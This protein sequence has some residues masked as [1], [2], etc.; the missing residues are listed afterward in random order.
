MP[1]LTRYQVT[2]RALQAAKTIDE[3]GEVCSYYGGIAKAARGLGDRE[4]E[5]EAA[6][7][8]I[9]AKRKLGKLMVAASKAGAL[10]KGTRGHLAGQNKGGKPGG[11]KKT[12]LDEP[13]LAGAHVDKNLAN[14]ARKLGRLEPE[15]FNRGLAAWRKSINGGGE[16]IKADLPEPPREARAP[17][18]RRA[19]NISLKM[20]EQMS[21]AERAECLDPANYPSDLPMNTQDGPGIEWAQKSWNPIVGCKHDCPYCYARDIT[22]RYPDAFP[23][24]FEPAFRP[25]MLNA[26]RNT[27][28]PKDAMFDARYSHVFAGSMTDWF[29]R[30]V[31]SEW[32]EAVLATMRDNPIWKFLCLSKFPKRMAEF[33]LPTNMWAGTTVDLQARVANA[34]MAFGK[35]AERNPTGIRW[36]SIEP[37]L[38]PLVFKRLNLF[39]WVVI[40]GASKS[41]KTPAFHPP[42]PWIIDIYAQAKAAGCQ[43]YMKTNLLGNRVL[44]LPFD[45]PIKK[46]PSEADDVFHYLGRSKDAE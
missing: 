23:H 46:D 8:A 34:E 12:R 3:V 35:L 18:K 21:E 37:L 44:E 42:F 19:D 31:P 33:D 26:P 24:G 43:V 27:S 40:G 1:N 45:A 6:E 38:E 36:L 28:L 5:I 14:S 9:Q 22:T 11:L 7:L 10:A 30:W 17:S 20:W 4:A 25:Y 32:I 41:S 2:N 13:T 39:K 29:G 15:E 16:R